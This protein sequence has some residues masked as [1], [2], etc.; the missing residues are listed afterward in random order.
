MRAAWKRMAAIC[1]DRGTEPA[2]LVTPFFYPGVAA[3][4]GAVKHSPRGPL[5]MVGA[6]GV[7][8]EDIGDRA[9]LFPPFERAHIEEATGRLGDLGRIVNSLPRCASDERSPDRAGRQGWRTSSRLGRSAGARSQPGC[10][11]CVRTLDPA[12]PRHAQRA[13]RARCHDPDTHCASHSAPHIASVDE[14]AQPRL[15]EISTCL[16]TLVMKSC[17]SPSESGPRSCGTASIRCLIAAGL[18][19]GSQERRHA[20]VA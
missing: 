12:C 5:V 14:A 2:A 18:V 13:H 11:G 19:A 15:R 3:L 4:V 16:A 1:E 6:G 20:I 8:V 17:S 10:S 9:I 7:Y